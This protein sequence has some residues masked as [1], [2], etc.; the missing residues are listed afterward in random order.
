[1]LSRRSNPRLSPT[2]CRMT[3]QDSTTIPELVE[4]RPEEVFPYGF[5]LRKSLSQ[6][7]RKRCATQKTQIRTRAKTRKVRERPHLVRLSAAQE[8]V[9]S[10]PHFLK[11][12]CP[13][14]NS[15]PYTLHGNL[16]DSRQDER[17]EN[18]NALRP[19]PHRRVA[20]LAARRKDSRRAIRPGIGK[21]VTITLFTFLMAD[22][23]PEQVR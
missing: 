11:A 15:K 5:P 19:E 6:T 8:T 20:L 10:L 7:E 4:N 3:T 12:A 1:V 22:F 23:F 17:R 16:H 2:M 9:G 13:R 21:K 18:L 14:Y